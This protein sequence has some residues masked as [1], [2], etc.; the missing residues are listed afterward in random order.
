MTA[1]A[2]PRQ[3]V[4]HRAR[5]RGVD[6]QPPARVTLSGDR[7]GE[8][9]VVEER[10]DGS[11][12]LTPKTSKRLACATR[13]PAS[14][15]GTLLSTL[16]RPPD[17]LPMSDVE[18]LEGWGLEPREDERIREVFVA[19]VDERTGFLAITSERF[20][21]AADAGRGRT[22][23]EEHRLSAARGVELVRRGVRHKLRVSWEGAVSFIS[24]LDR[25]A[26][27]RLQGYLE[28]A[29]RSRLSD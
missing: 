6:P 20:V 14:P 9:V 10:S 16:R 2:A 21:F 15:I 22:V 11:L 17:T 3:V 29:Q 8:Y 27:S 5:L 19:D 24:V 23:V 7:S 28:E 4:V 12:V 1:S 18:V 25:T 26:L 13:R